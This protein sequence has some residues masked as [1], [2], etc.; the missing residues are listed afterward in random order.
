MS[1]GDD[2]VELARR[3]AD[4]IALA[5]AHEQLAEE[6]GHAARAQERA[7]ML[8]E[9]VSLLVQELES[10]GAHRAL[11]ESAEWKRALVDAM[12]VAATDT[13]VLITGESGTGKEVVAAASTAA[14]SARVERSSL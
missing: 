7:S 13:T 12:K 8:E 2:D 9:R 3:I 5:F 11:G 4:H 10:R 1:D 14:R 6:A